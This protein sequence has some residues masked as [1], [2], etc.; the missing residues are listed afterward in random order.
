MKSPSIKKLLNAPRQVQGWSS[1][2]ETI[3]S[4][5]KPQS[6]EILPKVSIVVQR[7]R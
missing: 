1:N 3:S 2:D 5:G 7:H 6:L 4:F